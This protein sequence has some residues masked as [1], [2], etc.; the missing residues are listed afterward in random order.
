[1][2][3]EGSSDALFDADDPRDDGSGWEV[4]DDAFPSAELEAET[5]LPRPL[6]QRHDS[7]HSPINVSYVFIFFAGIQSSGT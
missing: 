6:G 7:H 4:N 3:F 2:E 1:M 5:L